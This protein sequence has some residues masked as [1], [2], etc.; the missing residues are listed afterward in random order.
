MRSE[1]VAIHADF[2]KILVQLLIS[3]NCCTTPIYA[4]G[5]YGGV[6][7]ELHVPKPPPGGH[8]ERR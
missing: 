6:I 4:R 5:R 8:G 2:V 7:P 3:E 1:E